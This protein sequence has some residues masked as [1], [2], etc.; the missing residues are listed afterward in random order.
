MKSKKNILLLFDWFYPDYSAGGPVRSCINLI[1]QTK[2]DLSWYVLTSNQVYQTNERNSY[3]PIKEWQKLPFGGQV[4]YIPMSESRDFLKQIF[5]QKKWSTIYINSIYSSLFGF[6]AVSLA[7]QLNIKTVVCPRGMLAKG[8]IKQKWWLKIPFLKA[9]KILGWYSNVHWHATNANEEQEI[10]RWFKPN[11]AIT[12]LPNTIGKQITAKRK[13]EKQPKTIELLCIAR[14]APEKNLEYLL[15]RLRKLQLEHC[16][17]SIAGSI[18][19]KSYFQQLK[20]I[21]EEN[22]LNISFLGHIEPE[23]LS[24]QLLQYDAMVLPTLGEN[25][26]H[27]IVEALQVGLPV[28]TSDLTPWRNLQDYQAGYDIDLNNTEVFEQ[29]VTEFYNLSEINWQIK[30]EGAKNY[31]KTLVL[32]PQL[33]AD[34]V[35]FFKSL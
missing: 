24:R 30:H 2:K 33:Q 6:Q 28:I 13:R 16:H 7:K 8:S 12:L 21:I 19:N 22:G 3:L 32:Q 14:I 10:K 1:S 18:Y 34:Y 27:A 20:N 5:T 15:K 9:A 25:F 23:E 4:M 35:H 26:G 31:Y 17:L 11:N 29:A